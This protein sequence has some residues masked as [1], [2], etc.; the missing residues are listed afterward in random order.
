M[1]KDWIKITFSSISLLLVVGVAYKVVSKSDEAT[2]KEER[3][4]P[5]IR[6][7]P[8]RVQTAAVKRKTLVQSVSATGSA[9]AVRR[10]QISARI[11]A[12][13]MKINAK[14]GGFYRR[15]DTLMVFSDKEFRIALQE[16]KEE[17]LKTQSD[18]ATQR[19]DYAKLA[20]SEQAKTVLKRRRRD[21]DEAERAFRQGKILEKEL[22]RIKEEAE[23]A[24]ILS[25]EKLD[26]VLRAR[27]GF[28]RA[29]TQL[30]RAELN[31]Q[32]T[33]VLAPF[34]GFASGIKVSQ[35]QFVATGQACMEFVDLS[36][37]SV[38]VGILE[39][40]IPF[41]KVGNRAKVKFGAFA[42]DTLYGRVTAVSPTISTETKTAKAIIEL[43]NP[44]F[45]LKP[46]MYAS[47]WIEAAAF[48]NRLVAPKKALVERDGRKIIFVAET[49]PDGKE[50]AKWHY[51][52]TGEENETEI[53]IVD[54]LEEGDEAIID[55]NFTLSHDMPISRTP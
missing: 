29:K 20:P 11:S 38:E 32:N 53:E 15:G 46:G 34:E 39:K 7:E 3:N 25:G 45:R 17:Y 51:V 50:L 49:Q 55:N 8:I 41:I 30:L 33:V 21:L 40:E 35:G 43:P 18:Y 1:K 4:L 14:E 19:S 9:E 27:S 47:V 52:Q 13:L 31:L 22:E 23:F 10:V 12:E 24:E 48:P 37:I 44:E 42:K 6:I 2:A 28:S 26:D 54:G 5:E 16:A 36:R